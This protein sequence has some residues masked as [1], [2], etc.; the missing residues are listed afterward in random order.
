MSTLYL[1]R[2]DLEL[3]I[4]GRT[5]VLYLQGQR[6]QS[7]P[8]RLLERVVITGGSTQLTSGVL[9]HLA[10][11]SVSTTV[12]HARNHREAVFL[13][14][15]EHRDATIR[16]NQVR[17]ADDPVFC[18]AWATGHVR[19]K[20]R[21]QLRHLERWTRKRPD[22][23]R[24]LHRARSALAETLEALH[25]E[26]PLERTLG[27]EGAAARAWFEAYAALLPPALG[28]PGRRRRPPPDPINAALSLAYTL[29]HADAVRACHSAGLDPRT[30]FY[31]QLSYGRESLASDLIEP[32]RPA[33]DA[34]VYGLFRDRFLESDHFRKDR[35]A[36]LLAKNGRARFF[37]AWEHRA[38][39]FRRWLRRETRTLIQRL[40]PPKDTGNATAAAT[41]E[42]SHSPRP[43]AHPRGTPQ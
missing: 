8:L 9:L 40:Q 26:A 29:L 22:Q 17:H 42:A 19:A 33:V 14:G 5:L 12:L 28:F 13:L 10:A 3:R 15:P 31:H 24:V 6:H 35:G 38:R 39:P 43:A 7:I 32:L 11:Y 34:W 41:D 27:L 36:I 18:R 4:D 20:T 23:N 30:G 21:R 1:D 2:R 37:G 16:Q 25:E